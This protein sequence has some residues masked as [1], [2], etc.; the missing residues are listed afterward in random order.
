MTGRTDFPNLRFD[1]KG[2]CG[3]WKCFVGRFTVVVHYEVCSSGVRRIG[4]N[5]VPVFN[6]DMKLCALLKAIINEGFQVLQAQGIDIND[7]ELTYE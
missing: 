2:V 3:L 7:P 1:S 6:D 4:E 5:K